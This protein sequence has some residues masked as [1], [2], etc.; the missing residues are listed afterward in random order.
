MNIPVINDIRNINNFNF[1]LCFTFFVSLILHFILVTIHEIQKN[2][3]NLNKNKNSDTFCYNYCETY[4]NKN[5]FSTSV[6][7]K[8]VF[9]VLCL[10]SMKQHFL[11]LGLS[12]ILYFSA[13][14]KYMSIVADF[15]YKCNG[16]IHIYSLNTFN[17]NIAL[18][19]FLCAWLSIYYCVVGVDGFISYIL[20]ILSLCVTDSL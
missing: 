4:N 8:Y 18:L 7:I 3:F 15:L 2:H 1:L 17:K 16:N 9:I 20:L 14:L 11:I 12:S 13:Y 10:I 19:L 5:I 6:D